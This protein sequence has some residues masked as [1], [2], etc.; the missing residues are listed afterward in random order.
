MEV[1]K[2]TIELSAEMLSIIEKANE[3]KLFAFAT[4]MQRALM[5]ISNNIA[6]GSGSIHAK[7]FAHFLNISHRSAF[8]C[9]NLLHLGRIKGILDEEECANFM[10][11]LDSICRQLE[12]F[13]KYLL[14][15][16]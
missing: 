5:S 8:E 12:S 3:K 14:S 1:W 6:E 13:R 4:Q 7:E 11:K 2:D 9:V 16:S 15:K 10:I